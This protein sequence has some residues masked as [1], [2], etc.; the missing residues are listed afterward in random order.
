MPGAA[1]AGGPVFSPAAFKYNSVLCN[2]GECRDR[3]MI[4]LDETT[5][6]WLIGVL[7]MLLGIMLGSIAT[8]LVTARNRKT[9]E[10]QQELSQ[11]RERFTDYRDQVTQHF[12]RTSELV[13]EMTRSYRDVYEHLAAGAQHLCGDDDDRQSLGH[14]A[15]EARLAD[16]GSDTELDGHPADGRA[17]YDELEELSSIKRDIDVLLGE[18]PR[19]SDL[20]IRHEYDEETKKPLQH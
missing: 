13:Q 16:A 4:T 10:L 6:T 12:M 11:L 3:V 14:A 20:D 5:S 18:S 2:R 9:H 8:Y 17:G 15:T 7:G 1:A 19:I